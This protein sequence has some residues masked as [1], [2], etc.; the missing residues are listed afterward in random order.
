MLAVFHKSVAHPPSELNS[1][2]SN[3]AVKEA[4][5]PDEILKDFHSSHPEN[6]FSANFSHGAAL[7][8]VPSERQITSRRILFCSFD[9]VHC[10][11]LGSV[12][13]LSSL[14]KRY[15]LC[16]RDNEALLVIEAYRTLRDRAPYPADQV[17]KDLD[18]SFGFVVYDNKTSTVFCA[19]S[20]DGMVPMHWGIAADGSVVISN[21]LETLKGCC[22][23]SFGTFPSGCMFHSEGGLRS[24]EHPMNKM[25][26]MPRVDSEGVM[27]GSN[28]N[29]DYFTRVNTMPRVGSAADW[30][31]WEA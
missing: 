17:V 24:F 3:L 10:M 9:D 13:N 4:K 5:N 27:C 14:I 12:N 26:P 18:G 22:G 19:K 21:E 16:Q 20:S 28:F 7:A 11:F 31:V 8:C 15:G 2:N 1:P 30:T 6:A 25:K 23:K 29:V